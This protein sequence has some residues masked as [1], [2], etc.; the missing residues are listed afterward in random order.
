MEAEVDTRPDE[1]D[2]ELVRRRFCELLGVN[3][4]LLLRVVE[5]MEMEP[6]QKFHRVICRV[7]SGT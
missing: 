2:V 6:G 7:E 3:V 1:A 4:E 5:K